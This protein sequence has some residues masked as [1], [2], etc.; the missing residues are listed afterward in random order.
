MRETT[1]KRYVRKRTP[2]PAR[3]QTITI[4][5]D[6]RT[7]SVCA[8]MMCACWCAR[9]GVTSCVRAGVILRSRMCVRILWTHCLVMRVV[10][11]LCVVIWPTIKAMLHWDLC[12]EQV[13][14]GEPGPTRLAY[15]R[16]WILS[17]NIRGPLACSRWR[18]SDIRHWILSSSYWSPM[19]VWSYRRT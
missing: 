15:S 19:W 8:C 1:I 3:L 6:E 9:A 12:S 10:V 17:C 5:Q 18:R 11:S 13:S 14:F 16:A 7:A 4:Q 2:T